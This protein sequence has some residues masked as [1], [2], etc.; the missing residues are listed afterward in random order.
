MV[1]I[2][3]G[4]THINSTVALSCPTIQLD[5]GG[6]YHA[7]RAQR[8]L[9]DKW[10]SLWDHVASHYKGKHIVLLLNGDLGELDTKRRTNQLITT[11]KAT[12]QQLV[13][14]TLEP[15]VQIAHGVIVI[16]GTMAHEGKSQWLEEATAADLLNVI[17]YGDTTKSWYHFQGDLGGVRIDAAHHSTMGKLPWTAANAANKLAYLAKDY[18]NDQGIKP[19]DILLRSHNH[20]WSDSGFNFPTRAVCLPCWS[21]ITEFGYRQGYELTRPHIGALIIEI[22]G[23]E[24]TL[25]DWRVP[26][27]GGRRV[28]HKIQLPPLN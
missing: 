8:Y 25:R 23:G 10:V 24:Y 16:R 4:D 18:Y 20:R 15:A 19:P 5:D 26:L 28:W 7:S 13:Y 22:D 12:I 14:D 11:N 6:T 1:I 27:P 17:P 2:A 21:W 3:T 9:W